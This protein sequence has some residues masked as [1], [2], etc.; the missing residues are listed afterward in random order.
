MSPVTTHTIREIAGPV[1]RL[2]ALLDTPDGAPRAVVVVGHPHPQHGG[3]MHNKVVYR[4]AKSLREIGCAVL[5][6][7]FRGVGSSL[8][9]FDE[10]H[11]EAD[12]FRAGIDF[13]AER[14]P[15]VPVWAA[16]FSFGAWLALTV[17]ARD[18][19]VT[20]LLGIAP[21]THYDLDAF[22][23][24]DKPKFLIHGERDELV[25]VQDIWKLYAGLA[26]PKELVVIDAA[27]HLFNGNVSEV[28][29]AIVDLLGDY[30]T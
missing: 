25:A 21:P 24:S 3:T 23:Q 20:L 17:G 28:G 27:D 29:D 18:P 1:G 7:N 14:Y 12:D 8:G 6:F 22:R 5:R 16:G 15:D 2:E 10:G 26:E 11:G 4:T 19:R 30:P 13:L 9:E